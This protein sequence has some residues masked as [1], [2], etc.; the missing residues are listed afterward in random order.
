VQL[1]FRHAGA[2]PIICPYTSADADTRSDA[3]TDIDTHPY[4]GADSSTH[5]HAG[6]DCSSRRQHGT[7]GIASESRPRPD[8]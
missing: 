8:C 2:D 1:R 4:A 7:A 3:C 6:A 5:T